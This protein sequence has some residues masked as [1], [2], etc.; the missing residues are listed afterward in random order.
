MVKSF[1]FSALFFC[2]AAFAPATAQETAMP[3]NFDPEAERA[4][5]AGAYI[6]NYRELMRDIV[7]AF[8]DFVKARNADFQ[9]LLDGGSDLL[10]RGVWENDLVDLHR[11]ELAGATNDDER[12]LLKLFSPEHPI[13]SGTPNR[14]FIQSAAGIVLTDQICGKA[15]GKPSKTMQKLIDEFG[16]K[17]VSIEHCATKGQKNNALQTLSAKG[18]PTFADVKFSGKFDTLDSTVFDENNKSVES[19]AKVKNV[20]ILTDTRKFADKDLMLNALAKTNFDLL[21]VDP[22]FNFNRALSREDVR[23]LQFK[24]IGTRR[25]VYAVLNVAE[26]QDTRAYWETT[27]KLRSPKWL[28]FVSETNPAGIIVDYWHP[29]WK[30]IIGIYF[31]SIMDL[32]F[33]G[34]VLQGLDNHKIYERIIPIN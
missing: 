21:I 16:L 10:T 17:V 8:G 33:D 12:F 22:F 25:L 29:A 23:S 30:R 3:E 26:A 7:L 2:A 34:V 24:Q 27:W 28:R 6:P 4:K 32:G 13:K 14:R 9:I 11:A 1:L 31:R 5:I 18:I 19:L 15:K 20:L